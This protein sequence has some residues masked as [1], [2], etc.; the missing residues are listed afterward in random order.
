MV[1]EI[2]ITMSSAALDR[3]LQDPALV[4]GPV[5]DFLAKA[6]FTVEAAGKA[7][8]PIDTGRLRASIGTRLTPTSAIVGTPLLYA[9]HVEY[10]TKPHFPPPAALQPWAR[11]HGFPKG[12]AG[13]YMVARA[14]AKRGTRA[15]PFMRPALAQSMATIRRLYNEMMRDI[16]QRW[17]RA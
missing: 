16:E 9:P 11:R 3:A 14:I 5:R 1:A 6:A 15:Q 8:A 13:A 17:G 12:M 7:K 4:K 10:G 2:R